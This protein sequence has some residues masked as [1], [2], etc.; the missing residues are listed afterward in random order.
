MEARVFFPTKL[1]S[2]TFVGRE[3]EREGRYYSQKQF[4]IFTSWR[5]RRGRKKDDFKRIKIRWKIT[6]QHNPSTTSATVYLP[7]FGPLVNKAS[8]W[9][10]LSSTTTPSSTTTTATAA[11]AASAESAATAATPFVKQG[12]TIQE[13]SLCVCDVIK[14]FI[15]VTLILNYNSNN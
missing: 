10:H 6:F 13:N 11:T 8:L 15:V 7:R 5:R 2:L 1:P 12:K 4:C 3:R 9:W 14:V